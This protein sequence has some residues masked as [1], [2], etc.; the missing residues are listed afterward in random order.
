MEKTII[1][2]ETLPPTPLPLLRK[3]KRFSVQYVPNQN[4]VCFARS[5][6]ERIYF[7]DQ[8]T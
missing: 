3:G 5:Q 1:K 4:N 2:E 6:R 7:Y 8:L